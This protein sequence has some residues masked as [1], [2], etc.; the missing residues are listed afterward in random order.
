VSFNLLLTN[1]LYLLAISQFYLYIGI[2][3][4]LV[5]LILILFAVLKIKGSKKS[6]YPPVD[7]KTIEELILNL[8]GISNIIAASKDGAR[9]SFKVQ[10]TNKCH[11]D[12]VKSSGAL[13][14]FVTGTTVKMMLPYDATPLIQHINHL[15]KGE[16]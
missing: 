10:S 7:E 16:N 13:G 8:G 2:A 11:L 9:L 1:Y 5:A 15:L 14:I 4:G 12:V 3:I 6:T